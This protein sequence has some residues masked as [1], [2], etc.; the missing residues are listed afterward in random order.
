MQGSASA[1]NSIPVLLDN[2]FTL[3]EEGLADVLLDQVNRFIFGEDLTDLEESSLH[4][5]VNA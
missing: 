1:I 4:D 5:S 2:I 3:A